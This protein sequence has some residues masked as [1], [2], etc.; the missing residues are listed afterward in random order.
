MQRGPLDPRA[1]PETIDLACRDARTEALKTDKA[2]TAGGIQ[3]VQG[4]S[5]H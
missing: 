5:W 4:P 1:V 2:D 3:H